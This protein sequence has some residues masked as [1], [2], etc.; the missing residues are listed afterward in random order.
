MSNKTTLVIGDEHVGAGQNLRRGEWLGKYIKEHKPTNIVHIGDMLTFDSLSAWDKN[1]ARKMEGRRYQKDIDAGNKYLDI[2]H[3]A[4]KGYT[5]ENLILTEG[6][7]EDRTWRYLD[8]HPEVEGMM[9][10]IYNLDLEKRGFKVIPYKQHWSY[11]GTD[12]T[13]VPIMENGRPVSGKYGTNR[14]LDIC[15]KS[16]VFGHTH[17]LNYAAI[18]RHGQPFLQQALNVGCYFE[19]I[20]EYAQGSMTSYWRGLVLI[21]HYKNSAFDFSI[22]HMPKIKARYG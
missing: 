4:S 13:H 16:V 8:T 11:M 15:T 18:C 10:Y 21:E 3:D 9:D 14:A 5:P 6:N 19:H 22:D 7:H 20:D 1:K 12:F 17:K 2:V